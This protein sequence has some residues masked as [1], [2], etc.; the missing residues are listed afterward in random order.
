[1]IFL[2]FFSLQVSLLLFVAV[3]LGSETHGKP[4]KSEQAGEKIGHNSTGEIMEPNQD[5]NETPV[6]R[7]KR[8]ASS[9]DEYL[10]TYCPQ[11][12]FRPSLSGPTCEAGSFECHNYVEVV[13]NKVSFACLSSIPKVGTALC[14][15][16]Y[17]WVTIDLG[18]LGKRQVRRTHACRCA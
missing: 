4:Y 6:L 2:L 15:P 16:K 14:V 1:M 8:D 18:S 9:A 13:C 12:G 17:E 10:K 3:L 7:R 5:V 11:K